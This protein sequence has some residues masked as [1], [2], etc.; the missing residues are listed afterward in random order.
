LSITAKEIIQLILQGGPGFCQIALTNACNARCRFCNFPQVPAASRVMADYSRLHQGLAALKMA[1]VHYLCFTGGEPLLYP[2]LMAALARA[3]DLAINTVL[4]TNGSLLNPKVIKELKAAGLE[5]LIISMDAPS[6]AEHDRHRGLPGLTDHIREMMP[7][8]RQQRLNP[9][10][11]VTLSRMVDD[12]EGMVQFLD[13]LGFR[14]VTFSYPVTQLHSHYLG[15]AEHYSVDFTPAELHHWFG[16]IKD[17][18]ATS[19]LA[20]LNPKLGLTDLQRQLEQRPGRF[21]CLAGYKYFFVDWDLKVSRCHYQAETL[22]P[23]EEI[24]LLAPIRDG[25]QACTLDC[26]RD[27]SVYQYLA[28]SVA[29]GLAALRQGKWLRG[30]GALLHPYNFLSLAALLEGRHWVRG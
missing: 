26:Y 13:G 25:C 14:R 16:R 6:A 11:S 19:P 10:A 15:F 17:L 27:P 3:R 9:V 30:L 2:E 23:L 22:G 29:D 28:V 1:G 8:L 7:L 12:L 4:C 5:N 21:P 24:H 20:I 18:K